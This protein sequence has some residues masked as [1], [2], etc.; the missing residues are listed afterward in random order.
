M[1]RKKDGK[2][3][4]RIKDKDTYSEWKVK[5]LEIKG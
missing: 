5:N 2:V 3:K 4:E 1:E